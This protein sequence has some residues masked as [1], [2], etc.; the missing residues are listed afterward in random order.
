MTITFQC[1]SIISLKSKLCKYEFCKS[2]QKPTNHIGIKCHTKCL[3]ID[4]DSGRMYVWYLKKKL[5][6]WDSHILNIVPTVRGIPGESLLTRTLSNLDKSYNGQDL[7][8]QWVDRLY[9]TSKQRHRSNF[10]VQ[11]SIDDFIIFTLQW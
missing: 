6:S 5:K 1:T 9:L 11:I 2:S 10:L 4:I 3:N 7:E 8:D